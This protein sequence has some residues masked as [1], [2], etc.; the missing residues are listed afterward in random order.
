MTNLARQ[1]LIMSSLQGKRQ[2]YA[3]LLANAGV[4]HANL[5]DNVA[6]GTH[7]KAAPLDRNSDEFKALKNH[8][9]S[10]DPQ[11]TISREINRYYSIYSRTPE[12]KP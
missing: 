9:M 5:K 7:A 8:I 4:T 1:L 11:R 6:T 3:A 12:Q 2:E 10:L